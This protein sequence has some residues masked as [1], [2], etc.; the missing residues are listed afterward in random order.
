[1]RI[2]GVVTVISLLALPAFAQSPGI[3]GV[4]APGV[5]PKLV[6]EGFVF[7]EGPVGTADGGLYFSDVRTSRLYR[8]APNGKISLVREQTGGGNGLAVTRDGTLFAVEGD[9]KRISKR[10]R[11][12]TVIAVSESAGGKPYLAPND[13]ILDAK[14]GIY[15]TDPGPRPV[16]PGRPTFV[17]YLPAGAAQPLVLDETVGRPN[18]VILTNNGKTLIVDDSIGNVVFAYDVQPDGAVRNKRLFAELR[19][20][21]AGQE[22][23]ADG[24]ALDRDDRL[25]VTTVVGVQVFDR[26]GNHLGTIKLPR[27][28]SNAAFAGP[29]KGTLYVTA[30]EGVYSIR[31]LARGPDRP[32]K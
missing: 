8:L 6:Q 19:D 4:V 15:A 30:R 5:M 11:D 18:G 27:Q 23:A 20:I 29:G 9:G 3:P 7:T 1:M 13:L 14:G 32:G 10:T 12:G 2:T 22:S 25:Y 28:P 26:V 31:M 24:M 16:V 21:P 17:Y